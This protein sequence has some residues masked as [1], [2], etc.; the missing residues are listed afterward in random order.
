MQTE[1]QIVVL[2]FMLVEH[3]P[4]PR[5]LIRR[6]LDLDWVNDHMMGKVLGESIAAI[7]LSSLI[8]YLVEVTPPFFAAQKVKQI[9][10]EKPRAGEMLFIETGQRC[11][12][13]LIFLTCR[14]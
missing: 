10:W 6:A 8:Q 7:G 9:R 13:K 11:M 1:C 5:H 3:H 4:F 12:L 2:P 14:A